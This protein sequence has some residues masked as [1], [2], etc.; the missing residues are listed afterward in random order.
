MH[1]YGS[2]NRTRLGADDGLFAVT[3]LCVALGM[4]VPAAGLAFAAPA[5]AVAP[6]V[7]ASPT[8]ATGGRA[9]GQCSCVRAQVS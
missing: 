5:G 1:A 6:H 9:R 4:V 8:A 2:E 3:L 7:A